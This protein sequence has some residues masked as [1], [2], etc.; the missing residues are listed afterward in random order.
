MRTIFKSCWVV[1]LAACYL[2]FSLSCSKTASSN[3]ASG[4]PA[5]DVPPSGPTPLQYQ[6]STL[7][8]H[9][10]SPQGLIPD[11]QGNLYV[12]LPGSGMVQ[13]I[14]SSGMVSNF[15]GSGP[16]AGSVLGAPEGITMD[17]Q[18]N[19]Y[20]TD[21]SSGAIDRISSSGLITIMVAGSIGLPE[22]GKGSA[23]LFNEPFGIT[24]DGHGNLYV[25]DAGNA[26][27]RKITPTGLISTIASS[28]PGQAGSG[29]NLPALSRPEGIALD[30]QGNL[31]VTDEGQSAVWKI[32]PSGQMSLVAG[33]QGSGYLD[34]PGQTA[35]FNKPFGIV[36]DALGNL[37]IADSGNGAVRKISPS[38]MVSTI[39]GGKLI[40]FADGVGTAAE[41]DSPEGIAIDSEGNLYVSDGCYGAI[42][43]ISIY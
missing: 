36:S 32:T 12:A 37:Y 28:T 27:I 6:V 18:G 11:A 16:G 10:P 38:G 43:K 30:V 31:Y 24:M 34:G 25:A 5:N 9:I 1:I 33:G 14:S 22:T 13:R 19:L 8:N 35:M 15:A 4:R 23:P 21:R 39:A 29:L 26:S 40:G 7:V 42:R 20:L 41:F 17:P 3:P 2:L